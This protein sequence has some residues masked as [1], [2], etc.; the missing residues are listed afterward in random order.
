MKFLIYSVLVFLVFLQPAFADENNMTALSDR[1]GLTESFFVEIGSE[2]FEVRTTSNYD[3]IAVDF[4]HPA[5]RLTFSISSILEN[6][7]GE[8]QIPKDL[9]SG[10][11]SFL[12]ND[13]ELQPVVRGNDQISF[14]TLEFSGIGKNTLEIIGTESISEIIETETESVEI[15]P[16]ET[17]MEFNPIYL[18]IPIAIAVGIGIA[19]AIKKK[20]S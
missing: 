15:I 16:Q 6:N 10:E 13:Q 12:L 11:L 9:L 4:D 18:V 14:I 8:M 5:K 7:L 19:V 3:I 1:T 2:T 17:D 20:Q